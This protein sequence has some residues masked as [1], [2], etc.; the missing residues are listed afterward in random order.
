MGAHIASVR[1]FQTLH[2]RRIYDRVGKAGD[3]DVI[4]PGTAVYSRAAAPNVRAVSPPPSTH[5][6]FDGANGRGSWK[7]E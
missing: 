2:V 3:P 7:S 4:L 6:F 1:L 5:E